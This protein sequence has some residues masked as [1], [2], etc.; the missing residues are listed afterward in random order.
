MQAIRTVSVL[1][2]V[3]IATHLASAQMSTFACTG[4]LSNTLT[5]TISESS[6]VNCANLFWESGRFSAGIHQ[7]TPFTLTDSVTVVGVGYTL[8]QGAQIIT[9]QQIYTAELS[10]IAT[11]QCN[12]GPIN[13]QV[14]ANAAVNLTNPLKH[15]IK[16]GVSDGPQAF[17]NLCQYASP[18]TLNAGSYFLDSF[19]GGYIGNGTYQFKYGSYK[20]SWVHYNSDPSPT[21]I[22]DNALTPSHFR[23]GAF[24][25][26]NGF[27]PPGTI[28]DGTACTT[29]SSCQS[30]CCCQTNA[31]DLCAESASCAGLSGHCQ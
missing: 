6:T 4:Q 18:F 19:V 16:A 9:R 26:L 1:A 5:Y 22:A 8:P 27:T 28:P 10:L 29:S 14:N 3:L 12:D 15:S 20:A 13:S 31:A 17:V 24:L 25:A 7:L 23:F 21:T 30:S 2:I 11:T